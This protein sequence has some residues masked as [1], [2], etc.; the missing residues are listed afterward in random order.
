MKSPRSCGS[1]VAAVFLLSFLLTATGASAAGGTRPQW[2]EPSET[3]R[4]QLEA[5]E[6]WG[7][8][9]VPG[10][11]CWREQLETAEKLL[12]AFPDDLFVNRTYQDLARIASPEDPGAFERLREEYRA[13]ATK[14]PDDPVAQYLAGR[15][16]ENADEER[17][18][19]HKALAVA[20]EFP[21]AHRGL[22]VVE[23]RKRE[24][25]SRDQQLMRRE[26]ERFLTLCPM[27]L[28]A[29]L[30][31]AGML[32]DVASCRTNFAGLRAAL[33]TARPQEQVRAWPRLWSLEFRIAAVAEHPQLRAQVAQDLKA[34]E[35]LRLTGDP[36]WWTALSEGLELTGDVE[37]KKR[38]EAELEEK[39]PCGR[40][41][42]DATIERWMAD[43][44]WPGDG[45]SEEQRSAYVKA[46][47]DATTE[48]LA[49]CPEEIEFWLVRLG[50]IAQRKD[51]PNDAVKADLDRALEVWER[52]KGVVIMAESPYVQVARLFL[53][54]GLEVE[55]VPSLADKEIERRRTGRDDSKKYL[56]GK[57][58]RQMFVT[59]SVQLARLRVLA[60]RAQLALGHKGA[61]RTHLDAAR[62]ELDAVA[63]NAGENAKSAAI[64]RDVEAELWEQRAAL[65]EAEGHVLDA[66]A[67]LMKAYALAPTKKVL[68]EK[69]QG[70]WLQAGG[71]SE[72]WAVLRATAQTTPPGVTVASEGSGWEK[73]T[74][75]LKPFNLQALDGRR[76]TLRDLDGKVAFINVWATWCG[77]CREELRH[78]QE[79]YER[80][81]GRT[82]LVLLTL[83]VDRDVGLV[84]PFMGNA[85][86]TF[87]ALLAEAYVEDL[88]SGGT[89][90]PR[91]LI[92]DRSGVVRYQ[93]VGF[94]P[95]LSKTWVDGVVRL[96]DELTRKT[97][98]PAPVPAAGK[99]GASTEP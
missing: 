17:T 87:P 90:I 68:D 93:Q 74:T 59:Y 45:A 28:D 7:T 46:Y 40:Q 23:G 15:I 83:N 14:H 80:V 44:Q 43:H 32:E 53:D 3:L 66:S 81:K 8:D 11:R 21:W 98:T 9:C 4:T 84:A 96:M 86:Y 35:A 27:Q 10:Q 29:A 6:P 34:I 41:A 64:L 51:L 57:E 56:E 12:A 99:P 65:A 5:I 36:R 38:L 26:F 37:G 73:V 78:V 82:A 18:F 61:A 1:R 30:Q 91:N 47:Y 89:P 63:A 16:A 76:W 55:R 62:G 24:R 54:R 19:Y 20:P 67:M 33:R 60:G 25:A 50:V 49:R 22:G 58:L 42:V 79:L 94:E 69:A 39:R 95:S 13:R 92:L 97:A 52:Y 85:K 2:C 77:P 72:G 31:L 88:W 70:L 71:T 75:V 48:W